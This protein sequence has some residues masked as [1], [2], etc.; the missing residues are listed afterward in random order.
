MTIGELMAEGARSRDELR[1]ADR[2]AAPLF[3]KQIGEDVSLDED[4][5]VGREE[6]KSSIS[7][8]L[9]ASD[10]IVAI[11]SNE[12]AA[13]ATLQRRLR[14]LIEN[15]KRLSSGDLG[16]WREVVERL[17]LSDP[18]ARA[19]CIPALAGDETQDPGQGVEFVGP[20]GRVSIKFDSWSNHYEVEILP[21]E[22][23]ERLVLEGP[24]VAGADRGERQKRF[25]ANELRWLE[26][27]SWRVR[28]Q[29][30]SGD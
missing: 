12:A 7:S 1:A 15:V 27:E 13:A 22:A 14:S 6:V 19:E 24:A 5:L 30:K 28:A 21:S 18:G 11:P 10:S 20:E 29:P 16:S 2:I 4:L 8:A 17:N 25:P 3:A 23:M 9:L 26:P